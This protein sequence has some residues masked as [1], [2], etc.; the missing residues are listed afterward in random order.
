MQCD[1]AWGVSCVHVIVIFFVIVGRR[2]RRLF[3]LQEFLAI[4]RACRVQLEPRA[5]TV[6]VEAM[7]VVAG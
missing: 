6:K 4:K 7:I 3:L 1:A 5:Y 2:W